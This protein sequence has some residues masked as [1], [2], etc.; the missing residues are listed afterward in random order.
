MNPLFDISPF[1]SA[2]I[3]DRRPVVALET[4][5]VTHG[6]PHPEGV[7]AAARLESEVVA[8]GAVPATIGVLDGAVRIGLSGDELSRLATATDTVKLNLSNLAAQVSAGRPGSTTVAA[9]LAIAAGCGIRVFATGGIGGGHRGAEESGDISADLAAL[10]KHPVAVVCA[11]A[12]AV[13]DLPRTVEMLESLGVP[14]YGL[15][16]DEFPAFYRRGSGLPVDRRFDDV[17][18]LARAI[19]IHDTLG[20]GTGTVVA[21]P[22]PEEH[23]MPVE[24][25]E[26]ALATAL[27]EAAERKVRGRDVTPFLLDRIRELTEGKTVFSNLAL[28]AHNA[29]V[30]GR[31]SGALI[32]L[33]GP[34]RGRSAR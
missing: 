10:A 12:K 15:G 21:N 4:T 19:D 13:L 7:R 6:L 33:K 17:E 1:V 26:T 25:Y 9:T 29:R 24:L 22:I 2:A 20:L 32:A 34:R 18:S 3:A 28:L 11:G 16:T 27:A 31:L 23:E 5:L 14:V 30:A 8:A